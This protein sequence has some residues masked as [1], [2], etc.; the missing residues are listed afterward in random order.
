MRTVATA[1]RYRER[2]RARHG[3]RGLHPHGWAKPAWSSAFL[4]RC[5]RHQVDELLRK[6]GLG[7][8]FEDGD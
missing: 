1:I 3:D 2:S 7:G 6:R 5:A 4:A 8:V